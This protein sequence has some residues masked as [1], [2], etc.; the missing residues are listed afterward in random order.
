MLYG[1]PN[2]DRLQEWTALQIPFEYNDFMFPKLLD[3][4]EERERRIRGY[5]A[6]DRD[7]SRDTIHGP[8]LDI[9]VHSED[10][11]IREASDVRIRQV[12]DIAMR[13]QTRAIILHTNFI[14]NFYEPTYRKGWID[15]NEA[16]M[17]RLLE[18][19][20]QLTVYM[21]NMFDEEPD[22]LAAL[23][24]RMEGQRFGICLDIAHAHISKTPIEKWQEVCAP[25]V[26][27]YHINDN[28]GVIDAHLPL[29]QGNIEWEKVWKKIN[30]E[31]S[32]LIEVNSLERYQKSVEY[33]KQVK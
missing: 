14:P 32:M 8:F 22:C 24:E 13:L 21:E 27:H 30:P 18:D 20:P 28:H 23:A 9:T 4:E 3:N 7:R 29:G 2:F 33:L 12:C 5:L 10:V 17:T 31:A 25:W 15:R 11:L 6:A 19:Y 26:K 1:I 16:Y